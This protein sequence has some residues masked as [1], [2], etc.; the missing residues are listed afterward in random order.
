MRKIGIRGTTLEWFRSYLSNRKQFVVIDGISS[1]LIDVT[2]GSILG[3]ILFLI[4]INDLPLCTALFSRLFADDTT[5]SACSDNIDELISLVN[6]EVKKVVT[7]FRENKLSLHPDKT[8]FILFTNSP[9]A[10][11]KNLNVVIN[12]NNSNLT[13]P[14]LIL[15]MKR[16]TMTSEFPG[17]K[18]LG[19]LF[20]TELNFKLHIRTIASKISK[21]LFILRRVK[22]LL[23][24]K[25]LKTLYY[26][27]VH[28]H[29]IY[30]IH[31]WSS[32]TNSN[33]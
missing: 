32:S 16:V 23:S 33:F 7:F 19:I 1:D 11:N 4:Y 31:I 27:L 5:L 15:P 24:E 21:S 2:I 6:S 13:N 28:C 12:F 29:L 17:V 10:K 30:G 14:D 18:F 20:Y 8:Q 25:W 3:P 22:N 26:S 9:A